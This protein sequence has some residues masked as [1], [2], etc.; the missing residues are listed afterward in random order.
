MSEDLARVVGECVGEVRAMSDQV[1]RLANHQEQSEQLLILMNGRVEALQRDHAEI[2]ALAP[3]IFRAANYVDGVEKA[4][5]A[6]KKA[7]RK[8]VWTVVLS[9]LGTLGAAGGGW[10]LHDCGAVNAAAQVTPPR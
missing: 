8:V 3:Q 9:A 6:R 2:K 1:K 5:A 4:H 10:I 7:V